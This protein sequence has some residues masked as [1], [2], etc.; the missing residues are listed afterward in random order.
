M[1][2]SEETNAEYIEAKAGNKK[3]NC[4]ERKML[5]EIINIARISK[6]SKSSTV[7]K[8]RC[9]DNVVIFVIKCT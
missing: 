9:L 5:E 6:V 2:N 4:K 3:H 1:N 7:S 8:R